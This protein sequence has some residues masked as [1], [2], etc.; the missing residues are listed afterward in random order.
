M[1]VSASLKKKIKKHIEKAYADFEKIEDSVNYSEFFRIFKPIVREIIESADISE[2]LSQ[3]DL[4]FF[5][6]GKIFKLENDLIV[7]RE[8]FSKPEQASFMLIWFLE[9]LPFTYQVYIQT[10][11]DFPYDFKEI[12]IAPNIKFVNFSK[13]EIED[14]I[15]ISKKGLSRALLGLPP[16]SHLKEKNSFF[17]IET[18]GYAEPYS[19][20]TSALNK[21]LS[22]VKQY[23]YLGIVFNIFQKKLFFGYTASYYANTISFYSIATE[24]NDPTSDVRHEFQLSQSLQRFFKEMTFKEFAFKGE[25]ILTFTPNMN[26]FISNHKNIIDF[27]NLK[28]ESSQSIK[29]ALE[30]AFESLMSEDEKF[31][32]VQS[33]IALEALLSEDLDTLDKSIKVTTRTYA[34]RCAYLLADTIEERLKLR[35]RFIN[36]YGIRNQL[37]HG[38]TKELKK[39]VNDNIFYVQNLVD[40]II[41]KEVKALIE[42]ST[43]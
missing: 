14:L 1:D 10:N 35:K 31:S 13:K 15:D 19:Y 24:D 27:L 30:W 21:A 42:P 40:K 4:L 5:I 6:L 2:V 9:N 20:N 28:T 26:N 18:T 29:T 12:T 17:L 33:C 16:L 38:K 41:Y 23:I 11:L 34:D 3:Q 37:V 39:E 8:E 43:K 36:I 22:C 32:Y 25:T 7:K